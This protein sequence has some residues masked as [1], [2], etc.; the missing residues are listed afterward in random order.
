MKSSPRE[1][2]NLRLHKVTSSEQAKYLCALSSDLTEGAVASIYVISSVP[3]CSVDPTYIPTEGDNVTLTCSIDLNQYAPGELVWFKNGIEIHRKKGQQS[4]V[5]IQVDRSDHGA[6][7][8]CGLQHFTLPSWKWSNLTCLE[9]IVMEVKYTAGYIKANKTTFEV[10]VGDVMNLNCTADGFPTPNISWFD[11][12]GDVIPG[13]EVNQNIKIHNHDETRV[14]SRLNITI[15]DESYHGIYRCEAFNGITSSVNQTFKIVKQESQWRNTVVVVIAV[16][17]AAVLLTAAAT[18]LVV[19]F[20]RRRSK[21]LHHIKG[22]TYESSGAANDMT[23]H[24]TQLD[25]GNR[26]DSE[27][28]PPKRD[29]NLYQGNSKG[30]SRVNRGTNTVSLQQQNGPSN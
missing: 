9:K 1:V 26:L 19:C 29:V 8:D 28:L 30:R 2:S 12:D 5:T 18:F 24:L 21:K 7:Y 16:T 23:G 4:T 15:V 6:T 17:V 13:N 14:T 20:C 11:S 22:N 25:A 10:P 3:V 27:T